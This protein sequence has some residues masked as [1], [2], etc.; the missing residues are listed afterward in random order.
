M[1]LT[2]SVGPPIAVVPVSIAVI[3]AFPVEMDTDFP[4]TVTADKDS[5]QNDGWAALTRSWNSM[6]PVNKEELVPPRVNVP[7]GSSLSLVE[8][9]SWNAISGAVSWLSL[10]SACQNG[11]FFFFFRAWKVC[12]FF[13]FFFFSF[14]FKGN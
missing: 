9:A 14:F 3:A 12:F 1:E 6:L 11:S 8:R 13:F 7:P 10:M 2:S 4:C 5:S